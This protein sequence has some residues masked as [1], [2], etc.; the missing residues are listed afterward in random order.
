MKKYIYAG[1]HD[2]TFYSLEKL[3]NHPMVQQYRRP[4]TSEAGIQAS[5]IL[6]LP[7]WL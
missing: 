4:L 3:E 7:K 1:S 6:N 2:W 5:V